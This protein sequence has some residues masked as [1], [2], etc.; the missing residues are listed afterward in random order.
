MN[1]ETLTHL[2]GLVRP[3]LAPAALSLALCVVALAPATV[4]QEPAPPPAAPAPEPT[5]LAAWPKPADK[6]VLLK[7]VE[8]VIKAHVPEMA[9]QGR[10]ALVAAGASAVPLVLD[11]Y[12]RERDEAA[13]ERL[14]EVLMALTTAEHTRLLAKEFESKHLAVR[15]FALRRSSSF[16]DPGNRAAVEKAWARI[17]KAGEK[18]DADER[19][20]VA[21][22][23]ASTG[24]T[25]GLP[26]LF[27]ACSGKR[28]DR[29]KR[30]IRAALEGVRGKAATDDLL[31]RLEGADRKTKVAVLRMLAGCGERAQAARLRP[32]LD[33]EDNTI[34]VTAINALRGMVDGEPPIEDLAA[35][36]A[37]EMA[38]A[39]KGRA[40]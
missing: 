26:A 12:G 22:C 1:R 27:D 21:L 23:A 10:D 18:A 34:R 20:A 5:K 39:W 29:E 2:G 7:D 4:A 15:V 9:T 38:K 17:A 32:F 37:I 13:A 19:Y 35:F 28:W 16:P 14:H 25:V 36:E 3:V 6:D 24:S 33:E 8:R 31:A 11:R 30:E 40:L